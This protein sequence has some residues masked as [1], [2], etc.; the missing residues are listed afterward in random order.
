MLP[1]GRPSVPQPPRRRRDAA[2]P[3]PAWPPGPHPPQK[4]ADQALGTPVDFAYASEFEHASAPA[5]SSRLPLRLNVQH[6]II[7]H[8]LG[9]ARR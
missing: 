9:R 3:R 2:P 7:D 1:P 4:P 8:K 5:H 6:V